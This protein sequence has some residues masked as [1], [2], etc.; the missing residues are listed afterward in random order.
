[1]IK[2]G[3]VALCVFGLIAVRA[4]ENTVFYDP[5]I[6]YFK[7]DYQFTSVPEFRTGWLVLSTTFRYWLNSGLSIA[8]V[9]FLFSKKEIVKFSAKIFA[10][11]WLV[12]TVIWLGMLISGELETLKMIFFYVRR[13]LIQPLLV[14]ILVPA[15][16]YQQLMAQNSSKR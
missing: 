11:T 2:Y 14:F 6:A 12:F 13:F 7:G 16:Y 10:V 5:F 15:F 9:Y 3:M 4:V 1:M 8:I